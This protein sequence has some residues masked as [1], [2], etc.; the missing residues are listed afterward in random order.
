MKVS[1]EL[2][3]FWVIF[4][5]GL[6][7][8]SLSG[9][10][11][12][13]S[14]DNE[15]L[16]PDHLNLIFVVSSDLAYNAPGDISPDTANLTPQGLQRILSMATYLKK[17]VLGGENVTGIY[18]L[19]PM[20]HLQTANNYPDMTAIGSI[21]QFALL[22]QFNASI[23][24]FVNASYSSWT[25]NSYPINVSYA[26][27]SVP[28]DVI[29]PDD[30][31][32]DCTGLDFNDQNDKNRDLVAG[33][34]NENTTGFYVFSAPWETI[35]AL[36]EDINEHMGY[37]LDIPTHYKDPNHIYVISIPQYGDA[38]LVTY[39]SNVT[40]LSTYPELPSP[41]ETLDQ[42]SYALQP[43]TEISLVDGVGGINAPANINTNATIYFVRHAEAHPD[44][45]YGFEIGNFVGAGQWRALDLPNTLSDTFLGKAEP[46]MVY[47]CD[48]SQ[49]Y[50]IPWDDLNV[51]YVRPSLTILPYVIAN[52]LPYYL[53][54]HFILTGPDN[55]QQGSDFFF[56]NGTFSNKTILVAWESSRIKPM[57]NVLLESYGADNS[58][59][60]D[61]KWPSADYDTIWTVALDENGNLSVNNGLCEG[62]VSDTLPDE[63]PRF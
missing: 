39:D 35:S 63:A 52:D 23:P 17:S 51:S 21:Q 49:W 15:S 28:D 41:V 59:L 38:R 56:T 24:A 14:T 3:V 7:I 22:N 1:V 43:Y 48:P 37:G 4:L 45:K 42:C 55:Y 47:S 58:T 6:L 50:P 2:K 8:F 30:Y 19:E 10:D 25:A 46:E 11:L 34:I 16:N 27:G 53:V 36:L 57:I 33:I 5:T 44:P 13:S 18:A 60:L 26:D 9:C 31:C 54:S 12:E 32:P 40:P 62:I 20:T 61:T 29:A